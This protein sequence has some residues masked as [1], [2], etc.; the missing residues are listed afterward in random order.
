MF[1]IIGNIQIKLVQAKSKLTI[2]QTNNWVKV[3]IGTF[4]CKCATRPIF[5]GCSNFKDFPDACR[6]LKLY[7]YQVILLSKNING[8][9]LK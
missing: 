4:R 8:N 2:R 5:W 1:I 9:R 6:P 3:T 7:V